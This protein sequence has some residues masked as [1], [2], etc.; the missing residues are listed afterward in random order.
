M[1]M[2]IVAD[3]IEAGLGLTQTTRLVNEHRRECGLEDVGR[4]AVHSASLRLEPEVTPIL[5]SKQGSYDEE[6][7]WAIARMLFVL[8]LLS[9][10]LRSCKRA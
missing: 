8:Q 3:N 7:G 4:S 6:S 1:E 10:H 9:P 2:Q 5:D